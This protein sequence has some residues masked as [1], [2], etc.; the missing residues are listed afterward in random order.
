MNHEWVNRGVTRRH[1]SRATSYTGSESSS[2]QR[3]AGR[4]AKS[5]FGFSYFGS[6]LSRRRQLRDAGRSRRDKRSSSIVRDRGDPRIDFPGEAEVVERTGRQLSLPCG[7]TGGIRRTFCDGLVEL[8][9]CRSESRTC[10]MELE[11]FW[12]FDR[13]EQPASQPFFRAA[14]PFSLAPRSLSFALTLPFLRSREHSSP[15]PPSLAFRQSGFK[16]LSQL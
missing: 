3:F 13:R 1:H 6:R 9:R 12:K 4:S 5:A 7:L 10:L 15:I 11:P 8:A 16:L 2:R 14:S